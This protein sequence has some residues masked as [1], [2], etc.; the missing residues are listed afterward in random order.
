MKCRL[1]SDIK[2]RTR[3]LWFPK[4]RR[5]HVDLNM[6]RRLLTSFNGFRWWIQDLPSDQVLP[7][8]PFLEREVVGVNTIDLS[9]AVFCRYFGWSSGGDGHL[10]GDEDQ[11]LGAGA[12][13]DPV[14]SRTAGRQ[15]NQR[16]MD[17]GR[18]THQDSLVR[19]TSN[20]KYMS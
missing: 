6:Y 17:H 4:Q 19:R 5:Y 8:D 20:L 14:G 11:D 12:A 13:G 9:L 16:R 3:D 10:T 15:Q 2:V 1:N 18:Q 7:T